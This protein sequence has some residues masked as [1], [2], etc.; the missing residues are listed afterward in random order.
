VDLQC[1]RCRL[2]GLTNSVLVCMHGAQLNF[3][4]VT[5]YISRYLR[6]NKN[7]A[8]EMYHHSTGNGRGVAITNSHIP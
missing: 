8:Y 1:K 5:S 7:R 4:Y 3:D 2:F 6:D